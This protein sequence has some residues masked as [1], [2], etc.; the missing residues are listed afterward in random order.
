MWGRKEEAMREGE[1]AAG[2][3][4]GVGAGG[5]E[6]LWPQ[7]LHFSRFQFVN[8]CWLRA[9][10][11]GPAPSVACVQE[12][13]GL[14]GCRCSNPGFEDPSRHQGWPSFGLGGQVLVGL[15]LDSPNL[16]SLR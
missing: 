3:G 12:G 4:V 6:P 7:P 11:M 13:P 9:G 14:S 8:S 2:D 10:G 5:L 15:G 16:W 1:G